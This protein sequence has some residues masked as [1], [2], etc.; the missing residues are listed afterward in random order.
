MDFTT[1]R[2]VSLLKTTDLLL[3]ISPAYCEEGK[4]FYSDIE[5]KNNL[6]RHKKTKP[7]VKEVHVP[8]CLD[9]IFYFLLAHCC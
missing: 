2:H 7:R 6:Q 5:M 9:Q 4:K 8:K 3:L 1:F